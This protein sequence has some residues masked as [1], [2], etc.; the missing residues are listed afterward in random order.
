L[1]SQPH[2]ID[3]WYVKGLIDRVQVAILLWRLHRYRANNS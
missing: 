2:E 3:V 1:R